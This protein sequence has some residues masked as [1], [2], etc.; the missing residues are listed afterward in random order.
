MPLL[1]ALAERE[2]DPEAS[3]SAAGVWLQV[4]GAPATWLDTGI[5][6]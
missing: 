2:A 4:T 6:V 3:R 5:A 1:P